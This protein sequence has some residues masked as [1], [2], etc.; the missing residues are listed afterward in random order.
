MDGDG[1]TVLD[2][3]PMLVRSRGRPLLIR[4]TAGYRPRHERHDEVAAA[5]PPGADLRTV[6]DCRYVASSGGHH[7]LL[8]DGSWIFVW[9]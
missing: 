1:V 6:L 8:R 5:V 9:T 7:D 4:T 2:P 3:A